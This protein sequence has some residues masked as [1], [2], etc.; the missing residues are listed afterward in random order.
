M[1][2]KIGYFSGNKRLDTSTLEEPDSDTEKVRNRW[3]RP[4]RKVGIKNRLKRWRNNVSKTIDPDKLIVH[5]IGQSHIDCAW[6]WRYEQTRKKAQMTFRKAIIHS[7]M[8]PEFFCFA[9]SEPLLLEWVKEDNPDLFKQIQEMVKTGG[10]ELVGGSY[11]EPDCMMPSG[12]A[13]VRQRLY[14]MRF[15]RDHFGILPVVEWFL[16]SFGYNFGLPQILVKS[17]AKYFWTTKITW[18]QQTTFPFVNF[19]W[20][21]PDG[22]RILT[23]NFEMNDDPLNHWN[24][25]QVGRHLLKKDGRRVWNYTM[26]YSTLIE[27][28]EDEICPHIGYFFGR[29]DGGHGPTHSE[30]AYANAQAKEKMFKW[31][32]VEV[33]YKELEKYAN[34][35]PTWNDELYLETHRGCFSNHAEVKRHNRKHENILVSL[36]TLALLTSLINS[37]YKYPADMLESLWKTT[38]K[39]QFHDVLPGSSIPE[40]F[41]DCWDDWNDQNKCIEKIITDIGIGLGKEQNGL[42]SN[43]ITEIFLYNPVS[44]ERKSRVFIPI[45][46]FKNTP[47]LDE[48]GKP[49]YARIELLTGNHETYICQPIAAEPKNDVGHEP[50]GWWAVIKLK[51]VR[52]IPAKVTILD[53][54]ESEEI[55]KRTS[56]KASV[57]SISNGSISIKIDLNNGAMIELK[58]DDIRNRNNLLK[59]NSSNLTFGFLDRGDPTVHSWNLTPEYWNYP[60]DLPNDQDIEIKISE[61]GPIFASLEIRKTIGVSLVIQKLSLFKGCSE[62]F[63]DYYTDWKQKDTMLKVLYSTTTE[64]D[65]ATADAA[66][67]A[68]DFKTNPEVPCDKS[69]F[70]KICQKYFDLSS[71]DR[72][73]GLAIINEG[74]YAFDVNGGDMRIT[75]LRAC[76]Y[77]LPAPEAWVN[78]ERLENEKNCGHIIPEYN[79]LG[80]FY[81]RYAI[82]PHQGGTLIN[83]DG[84][85]N[86]DVKRRAEEFN[87][88]VVVGPTKGI[89]TTKEGAFA[90]GESFL[91]I[92]SPN[93]YL[94]AIKLKE[95][96]KTGTIIVRFVEG[97]GIPARAIIKL[98][99]KLAKKIS[100]I[101]AVDL[102][103]REIDYQFDWNEDTGV[104]SFN[105]G[106]FEISTFEL[107]L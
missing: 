48:D 76:K 50:S 26:D 63:L 54:S 1:R 53:E 71:P 100:A 10:I 79:G 20:Q 32:R 23:A 82:L 74:K 27:H 68:I 78:E 58:V 56:L 30:V 17:G 15:Y 39:N 46:V 22:T 85:P 91:E 103:E 67:C 31:S 41:D 55:R 28:V 69:R 70:E 66:Y 34:Q 3:L 29:G 21:G 93:V 64:A 61:L 97:S 5:M 4:D 40:V 45:S 72:K 84:T 89:Q 104:L 102:L 80:P 73:W 57:D 92:I 59:G 96:D 105:M 107:K 99:P 94:G 106:K 36:E 65:I 35:F 86:V 95:W 87:L 43:D 83:E 24:K 2:E 25:Y 52:V 7:K 19:W 12:E 6:M 33:F 47:K 88:P 38:L 90:S 101:K 98:N 42:S 60:L 8:F 18:N 44:W 16:D 62:V 37:N 11:V 75:M 81:C 9:L 51:A 13:F 49:N 77:P 14:G